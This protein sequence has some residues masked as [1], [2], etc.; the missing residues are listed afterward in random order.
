MP[1]VAPVPMER[2]RS[3]LPNIEEEL[4]RF[5]KGGLAY[6]VSDLRWRHFGLRMNEKREEQIILVDLESMKKAKQGEESI[7]RDDLELPSESE[8]KNALDAVN[9]AII[10]LGK[11]AGEPVSTPQGFIHH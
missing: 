11:R 1:Y 7:L 4:K 10:D 9:P 8:V 3:L 5:A 6:R 2:R